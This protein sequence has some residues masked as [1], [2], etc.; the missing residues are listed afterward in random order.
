[1]I[2]FHADG[3]VSQGPE[4]NNWPLMKRSS[5]QV[6][7][8]EKPMRVLVFAI[9]TLTGEELR[10]CQSKK[11]QG[12][13]ANP[14]TVFR[15]TI[16]EK[17]TEF[18]LTHRC[19]GSV[20]CS[21]KAPG[22]CNITIVLKYLTKEVEMKTT[23]G[24]IS[25]RTRR[26]DNMRRRYGAKGEVGT[27]NEGAATLSD[28]DYTETRELAREKGRL[29]DEDFMDDET[30]QE[31]GEEDEL[32]VQRMEVIETARVSRSRSGSRLAIST[33]EKKQEQETKERKPR[34]AATTSGVPRVESMDVQEPFRPGPALRKKGPPSAFTFTGAGLNQGINT[35][36][37][38]AT[39]Y[40]MNN[41][42][43]STAFSPFNFNNT[44]NSNA[45]EE[46][47]TLPPKSIK[48]NTNQPTYAF[49]PN[50][51]SQSRDADRDNGPPP[52]KMSSSN[53][54]I[55]SGSLSAP[56]IL[57]FRHSHFGS[58][59]NNNANNFHSSN[60]NDHVSGPFF[61]QRSASLP[62]L[63]LTQLPRTEDAPSTANARLQSSG[64]QPSGRGAFHTPQQSAL[65]THQH[66]SSAPSPFLDQNRV[67][68]RGLTGN[69]TAFSDLR[70]SLPTSSFT[71]LPGFQPNK[72]S[73][74]T[75]SISK[76]N[77][78]P[79]SEA[80]LVRDPQQLHSLRQQQMG[81]P[82][83]RKPIYSRFAPFAPPSSPIAPLP[84]MQPNNTNT[85]VLSNL[86]NTT[87]IQSRHNPLAFH[88]NA[89]NNGEPF[90]NSSNNTN[91]MNSNNAFPHAT[92]HIPYT[93]P[94]SLKNNGRTFTQGGN[95]FTPV[96]S[97]SGFEPVE[98][99]ETVTDIVPEPVLD[100][101]L[102]FEESSPEELSRTESEDLDDRIGDQTPFGAVVSEPHGPIGDDDRDGMEEREPGDLAGDA[103]AIAL[104]L[105][106]AELQ[107]ANEESE[108]KRKRR[109]S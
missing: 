80:L 83:E 37:N 63:V 41:S 48:T 33:K 73:A 4:F 61:Q 97:K 55:T 8:D 82:H 26:T 58:N 66:E 35:N 88:S 108:R 22:F 92:H 42:N 99:G 78:S 70:S 91:S 46:I 69:S 102:D 15:F 67:P 16:G 100:A 64:F 57:S 12:E 47:C 68:S 101:T 17:H 54:L 98:P 85:S 79:N 1:M 94:N 51:N 34:R 106:R 2:T 104:M 93:G 24:V 6:Y 84:M 5:F 53:F 107:R 45:M 89:L 44:N 90:S 76:S 38:N 75:G 77:I 31:P 105:A 59:N 49:D 10:Y 109:E 43:N 20:G 25:R 32:V 39:N 27:D 18:N 21:S 96:R 30:G 50:L 3:T 87:Q 40:S 60:T 28:G 56:D 95:A 23:I 62:T 52:K 7:Y 13:S 86:P 36:S 9:D 81:Q 19:K 65:Q 14:I 103:T 29:S 72:L 74:S 71:P 11:H